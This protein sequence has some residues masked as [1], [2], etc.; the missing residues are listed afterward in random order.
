METNID[1][2]LTNKSVAFDEFV[3]RISSRDKI[4]FWFGLIALFIVFGTA[5]TVL[6]RGFQA[7]DARLVG[8]EEAVKKEQKQVE[9]LSQ[10]TADQSLA[11]ESI[12]KSM[13]DISESELT[14][15]MTSSLEHRREIDKLKITIQCL[16][17]SHDPSKCP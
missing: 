1:L 13:H 2:D 6:Y 10:E 15:L 9:R 4:V 7:V 5:A 3:A 17:S 8:Y 16:K 12:R 14:S 11:I